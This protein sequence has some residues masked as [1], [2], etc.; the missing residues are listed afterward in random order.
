MGSI[1]TSKRVPRNQSLSK[2]VPDAQANANTDA[3]SLDPEAM[4]K[5]EGGNMG[6][7]ASAQAPSGNSEGEAGANSGFGRSSG[8]ASQDT[9]ISNRSRASKPRKG[10]AHPGGGW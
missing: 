7:M 2:K 4:S 1:Q 3:F 5:K 8:V 10:P 9:F 6:P